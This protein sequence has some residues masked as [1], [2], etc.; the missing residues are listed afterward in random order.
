VL[1]LEQGP[2]FAATA[3]A[4]TMAGTASQVAFGLA[5]VAVGRRSGWAV[6]VAAGAAAFSVSTALLRRVDLPPPVLF[7]LVVAVQVA[8]IALM[9]VSPAGS[10]TSA[11]PPPGWDL[12]ARMLVATGFVLLLTGLAGW[13]GPSLTGLLSPFPIYGSVLAVFAH[14]QL[15]PAAAEGVLRGLVVGLFGFAGFFLVLAMLLERT[16][17]G[18]AFAF[19]TLVLLGI[20][21]ASLWVLRRGY[22]PEKRCQKRW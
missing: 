12:P 11:P 2:A 18:P 6:A 5:Y 14:R 9:P 20:Q 17:I 1:A 8:A 7:G 16:G 10:S 3:A 19:A 21:G 15:G 13:L 22:G 4:G